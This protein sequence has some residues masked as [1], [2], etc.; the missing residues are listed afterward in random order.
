MQAKGSLCNRGKEKP[1]VGGGAGGCPEAVLPELRARE[2][3]GE[4]R[5]RQKEPS[6]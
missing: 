4:E 6:G 2:R 1:F 5:S 3:A